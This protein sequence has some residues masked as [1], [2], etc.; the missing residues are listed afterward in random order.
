MFAAGDWQLADGPLANWKPVF[1]NPSAEVTATL[2]DGER[3]VGVYVAYYRQQNYQRKVISSSNALAK[4]EDKV[5]VQIERGTRN[6]TLDG[7]VVTVRRALLRDN[8]VIG[9][10][11]LVAWHWYWINGRLTASDIAGKVW[12]AHARLTG[13]GDDSAAIVIFA[14]EDQPGS[15]AA[16]LQAYLAGGGS[17]SIAAVLANARGQR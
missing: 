10:T 13:Q 3:S 2:R 4:S 15:A 16:A 8:A 14:P 9:Q 1:E 6:V 7:Q 17:G 12:L 11:R 5:W